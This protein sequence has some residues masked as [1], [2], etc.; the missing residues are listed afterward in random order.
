MNMPLKKI[1]LSATILCSAGCVSLNEPL[2]TRFGESY[3]ANM[4]AQIVDPTPAEGAPM[5]DAQKADAAI[6]RYRKD[7]VKEPVKSTG[8]EFGGGGGDS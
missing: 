5:M 7:E 8:V 6:E 1:F 2:S 4:N 3:T